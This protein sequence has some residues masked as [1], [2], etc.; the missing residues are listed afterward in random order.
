MQ[1]SKKYGN[2]RKQRYHANNKQSKMNYLVSEPNYYITKNFCKDL[3]LIEM[4]IIWMLM[5]KPV[6]LGLSILEISKIAMYEFCYDY[7]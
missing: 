1:F 2:V 5:I 6:Y 7:L 4:K 3:L